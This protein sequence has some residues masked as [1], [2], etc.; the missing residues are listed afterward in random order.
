MKTRV[1][2]AIVALLIVIPLIILG[3]NYFAIGMIVLASLAL[4]EM[5]DVRKTEKDFPYIIKIISYLLLIIFIILNNYNQEIF[6]FSIDYRIISIIL[7]SLL[8]PLIF[9]G[10]KK[11]YNINDAL[12]LIGTIFFLGIAF[13]LFILI[14]EY[15]LKY[16]IFLLLI[17]INTDNFAYI[18]GSLIGKH[19]L[20]PSVSPKK[21]WEGLIGGVFFGTLISGIY[22][23]DVINSD[24]DI[25][26]LI[27]III[28]LS[29]IGQLGDLIFS[30]I[31]RNYNKKDFSNIMPG[32]GGILDR[33]DSII[34]VVIAFILFMTII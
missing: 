8:S 31:K 19:K 11:D 29:L 2:S 30:S 28:I 27:S 7:L 9:R 3:G 24:V 17:T 18:T 16:I 4:K 33:L 26:L 15:S 23:Y 20:I 21:T 6:I 32:H 22:Y 25:I 14:R 12:F 10:N 13:S 5:I 34:L 1:I